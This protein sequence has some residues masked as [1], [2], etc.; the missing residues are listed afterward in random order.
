[1]LRLPQEAQSDVPLKAFW[2]GKS[3][4]VEEE[5]KALRGSWEIR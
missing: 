3:Q 1:M 2:F 4:S 5:D